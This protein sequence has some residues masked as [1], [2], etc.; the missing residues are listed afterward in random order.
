MRGVTDMVRIS[1]GRMSGTAFGAVVV[2]VAPEAAIGGPLALVQTGDSIE[3]DVPNRSLRV[4]VSDEELEHRRTSLHAAPVRDDDG[5]GYA[6]LY[7]KHVLQADAGADF[8]FLRGSRGDAV[9][10]ESH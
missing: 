5:G 8:D 9:G 10:R 3:L 7:R 4:D 2:H 6:W 1:D